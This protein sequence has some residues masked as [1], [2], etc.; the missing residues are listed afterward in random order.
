MKKSVK[1]VMIIVLLMAGGCT[2]QKKEENTRIVDTSMFLYKVS[3]QKG[4][5]S[6]LFGT[7]HPGRYP[8][9]R[10]DKVTEMA[11]D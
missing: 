11:L 4:G 3:D 7:F 6:Y 2:T 1:L 10:L 8:I 5:Y 9:K